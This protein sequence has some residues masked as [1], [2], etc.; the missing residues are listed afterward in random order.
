MTRFILITTSLFLAFNTNSQNLFLTNGAKKIKVKENALFEITISNSQTI[1]KNCCDY[2][3]LKGKIKS[4]EGDSLLMELIT[5]RNVTIQGEKSIE[6]VFKSESIA[7]NKKIALK[8]ILYVKHYKSAKNSKTK[9]TLQIIGG[10]LMVTSGATALNTFAVS[11]K[12]NRGNIL[13]SA[14]I[15][16][17]VGAIFIGVGKSKKR[18]FKTTDRPWEFK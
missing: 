7:L 8:D 6:S 5:V 3:D 9:K 14:G 15:Q 12:Q 10:V 13:L 2:M 16:L 11:G 18:Y 4:I 17:G 1:E